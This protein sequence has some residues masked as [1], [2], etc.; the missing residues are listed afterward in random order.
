MRV[1][2]L[3]ALY[4]LTTKDVYSKHAL[5]KLLQHI[6]QENISSLNARIKKIVH[7]LP[8]CKGGGDCSCC[9]L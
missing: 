8:E 7:L 4:E 6:E 1:N 2:A 3:Q 5:K 9:A